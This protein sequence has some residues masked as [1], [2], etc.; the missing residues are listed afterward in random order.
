MPTAV[1]VTFTVTIT[2]RQH[3]RRIVRLTLLTKRI[4]QSRPEIV[5]DMPTAEEPYPHA[6]RS[7]NTYSMTIDV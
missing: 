5:I 6:Q 2:S 1:A 4:F 7:I 3:L